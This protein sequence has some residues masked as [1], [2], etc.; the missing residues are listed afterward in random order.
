MQL[1]GDLCSFVPSG[2]GSREELN[3]NS[4]VLRL[5]QLLQGAH[6]KENQKASAEITEEKEIEVGG[7]IRI[8]MLESIV[9]LLI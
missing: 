7:G 2:P 4:L 6:K 9:A 5:T 3:K 1:L 8:H